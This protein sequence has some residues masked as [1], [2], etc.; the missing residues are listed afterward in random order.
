M[1]TDE[2]VEQSR[3]GAGSTSLG[4]LQ[5]V[6]ARDEQAW[7]RFTAL[8]T[9]LV[10]C[11]C[12]R[13]GLQ[14]ADAEDVCQ[15]VF[16]AVQGHLPTFRRDRPGDTFRGWLYTITS[17]KIGDFVKRRQRDPAA[18]GGTDAQERWELLPEG[19]AP[20]SSEGPLPEEK[21]LLYER[22]VTMLRTEFEDRTW[23]AFQ[24][25]AIANAAAEDVAADLG[26]T[27]NAVYVAKARV[28]RRL[29]EEFVDYIES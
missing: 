4:L 24:R 22:A 11:W 12:R 23:Q 19:P 18:L 2:N 27:V 3:E 1:A 6:Q 8:Y 14:D 9:P 28:L 16:G 21:R 7:R 20:P 26:M 29:R 25:T 17:H 13:R 10:R 5:Q 15:E